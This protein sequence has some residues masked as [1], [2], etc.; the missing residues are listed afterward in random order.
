[1]PISP[2]ATVV[3][4]VVAAASPAPAAPP[5]SRAPVVTAPAPTP[6]SSPESPGRLSGKVTITEK[7][8]TVSPAS[9]AV[10]YIERVDKPRWGSKRAPAQAPSITM[11][12]KAFDPHVATVLAGK[13]VAFPNTDPVFHNVFSLSP[14]N[15][16]D[17]GLYKNG[18]STD[19]VFATPGLVRVFCNIHPSM[20]AYVLVLQNPWWCTVGDDGAWTLTDVPPGEWKLNAWDER[21]G[22]TT[23][24]IKVAPGQRV[25]ANFEM[26]ARQYKVVPHLN[27]FGEAYGK[28]G[29]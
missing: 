5:P 3:L 22:E 10:V 15:K 28:K 20:T 23:R 18:K 7:D 11:K 16:F 13:S 6:A 29:Y 27:K 2:V 9:H 17:L 1:M 24:T 26:D 21:G 14:G 8:G 25:T 19:H 12:S 4:A